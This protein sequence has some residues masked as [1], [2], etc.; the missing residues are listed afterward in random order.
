MFFDQGLVEGVTYPC[1]HGIWR[2]WAP[3]LERTKLG[4]MA[5]AGSYGGAVLG[6]PVSG[7]LAEWVGWY[8]PFYVYGMAGVIWY[9]FW[10]WLSFEKPSKHPSITPREQVN[11]GHPLR[12]ELSTRPLVFP[13]EPS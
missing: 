3:P 11:K 13:L 8:A 7:Y 6:M 9:C 10:L 2:W 4:T 5:L 12:P 1:V